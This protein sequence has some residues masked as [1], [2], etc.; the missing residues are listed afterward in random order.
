MSSKAS[1]WINAAVVLLAGAWQVDAAAAGA[2]D[3][4]G[5]SRTTVHFSDLNVNHPAGAAIL[6]QRI[7]HAAQE[8]CGDPHYPGSAIISRSWQSCVAEAVNRAVV[9]V[10]RPALTAYYRLHTKPLDQQASTA[11]AAL[12]QGQSGR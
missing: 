4:A 10:D 8:V 9:A 11:L 12:S 7:R 2:P 6:Y 3:S 5:V 1:I